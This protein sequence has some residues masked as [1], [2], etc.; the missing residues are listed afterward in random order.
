MDSCNTSLTLHLVLCTNLYIEKFVYWNGE[1]EKL[2]HTSLCI[3]LFRVG[4]TH[5]VT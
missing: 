3:D 5:V 2:A 4:A 1:C